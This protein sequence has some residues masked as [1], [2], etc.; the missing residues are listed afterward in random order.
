MFLNTCVLIAEKMFFFLHK[1]WVGRQFV[2]KM[3]F[4][5]LEGF[6]NIITLLSSIIL[7]ELQHLSL[8]PAI[9]LILNMRLKK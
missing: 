9:A 1:Y 6:L 2:E 4:F 3:N 8:S 5:S 7:D